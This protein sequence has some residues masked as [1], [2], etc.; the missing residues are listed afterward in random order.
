MLRSFLNVAVLLLLALP[1]LSSAFDSIIT[2]SSA[3]S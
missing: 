3:S 1:R 2:I